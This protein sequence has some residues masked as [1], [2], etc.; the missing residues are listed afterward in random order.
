MRDVIRLGPFSLE[1]PIARGGMAEVWRGVHAAEQVPVAIKVLTGVRAREEAFVRALKNE[2]HAVARLDHPGIIVLY[3]RGEVTEE[4]CNQSGGRLVTGSPWFA[5][6]MC[7]HGALSPRRFPLEWKTTRILLLSLLDALAHAHARGVIHR[8]LKPGNILLCAPED[9]RMGLKLSDFGIAQPLETYDD[10]AGSD[11]HSGTPRYM[12][13]EQFNGKGREL[14]P[15][16]DLYALGCIAF[17][18]ATGNLPFAGDALRLAVAHCHDPVPNLTPLSDGYP[19]GF[20]AWVLRLLEKEPR[21]R[22][23]VAADA[24]WALMQLSGDDDPTVSHDWE[25][26]LRSLKPRP[27]FPDDDPSEPNVDDT[28]A[29]TLGP[30]RRREGVDPE[31]PSVDYTPPPPPGFEEPT[32]GPLHRGASAAGNDN[33]PTA[34]GRLRSPVS[35]AA[36]SG[37]PDISNAAMGRE[38]HHVPVNPSAQPQG[39]ALILDA[40]HRNDHSPSGAPVIG[41]EDPFAAV[42]AFGEPGHSDEDD[43]ATDPRTWAPQAPWTELL[44]MAKEDRAREGRDVYPPI[45]GAWGGMRRSADPD[46]VLERMRAPAVPPPLPRTWRRPEQP[47]VP[48]PP[49]LRLLGT[50]LG[51][52]GLR[53][54]PVVDRTAERDQL[55]QA[56][57]QAH[58]G[59]TAGSR[60]ERHK[61]AGGENVVVVV[62]GPAGIG[63]SRLCSWFGERGAEVGGCTTLSAGHSPEGGLNDGVNG[64]I[65]RYA[66]ALGPG[67]VGISLLDEPL[68]LAFPDLEVDDRA[69]LAAAVA[70]STPLPPHERHIVIRRALASLSKDR[71]VI[72][73]LDDAQWGADALAFARSVVDNSRR[74]P[75]ASRRH[76]LVIVLA[77]GDEALAERPS[78]AA[79]VDAIC[80]CPGVVSIVLPPLPAVDHRRLVEELLG[81]EPRLAELVATRSAGNP[82]FAV[83]LVGDFI[84]RGALELVPTGFALRRGEP[85]FLPDDIHEVWSKRLK[86]LLL[87]L[88]PQAGLCLELGAVLGSDS[89]EVEWLALCA[90]AGISEPREVMVAV[91]D[92]LERARYIVLDQ[93]TWRFAHAMLRESMARLAQ[94][95][96]RLVSHHRLIAQV[97]L[98][99]SSLSTAAIGRQERCARHFL[100]AGDVDTAM[101]LLLAAAA[102]ALSTAGSSRSVALIDEA[103]AALDKHGVVDA[104]PRRLWAI[105]LRARALAEA[106]RYAE[107]AMWARL[108]KD[109]APLKV[110]VECHRALAL[111]ALRQGNLDDT[112]ARYEQLLT[113]AMMLPQLASP[114]ADG[115]DKEAAID[116]A[117]LGLADSH[118]YR[119]HMHE[120]GVTLAR[121]L[122]RAQ[123]RDDDDAVAFCLWSSG[124][125]ALWSGDLPL[126]RAQL[127]RQQVVAQKA[128]L[129]VLAALGQNGLGDV[130]RVAGHL[131]AAA[132]HYDEAAR[133]FRPTGSGKLRV[134]VLN[135]ALCALNVDA[136]DAVN[137]IERL[138]PEIER[139]GER[140]L[141]AMCHGVL[142]VG[143]AIEGDWSAADA[144]L[145]AFYQPQ[146]DGLIDGEMALLAERVAQ[147]AF[148]AGETQRATLAASWAR[149]VWQGLGR[150]DRLEE[151]RLMAPT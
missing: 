131:A 140:V 65:L 89:D 51:L 81:L 93:G 94:E 36:T 28:A 23:C 50:G 49:A 148:A 90:A 67:F 121:L 66:R 53:H 136:T 27:M 19:V 113:L 61:L 104:D 9:P 45:A 13:P 41:D 71:P 11:A 112:V 78:T 39:A 63:R 119:G 133:Q 109:D 99:T 59:G 82:R 130:E 127:M 77:V 141:L 139:A 20:D 26:A 85:A 29:H 18:L 31:N 144:H 86:H 17:Q 123:A 30:P 24:A 108:V 38:H 143:A 68:R 35:L 134:V 3:D 88:P 48:L 107:S 98:K 103:F 40:V 96:G 37:G 150:N 52:Y 80:G 97:L 124:Y 83:E 117:L 129:K 44:A 1:R 75:Q 74:A 47:L 105:A 25:G 115:Y 42:L 102:S 34:V 146:R 101:P 151:L 46:A 118:Y 55:W 92:A 54:P 114:D 145:A 10:V 79:A 15:W 84:E 120:A 116:D 4:A 22:F 135:E 64:A 95:A 147:V 100:A 2:I 87:G 8:D 60:S 6:E 16:T 126:A 33:A 56:L 12:A 125:V 69:A 91:T 138:L 132:A 21:E 111:A 110:R 62:R 122:E 128:G 106:G 58:A 142:A 57:L 149:A 32:T 5:M 70:P 73:V 76:G 72:V 14:G 43:S 7:S 137:R